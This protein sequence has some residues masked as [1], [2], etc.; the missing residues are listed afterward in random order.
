MEPA[1]ITGGLFLGLEREAAVR[2]SFL[3]AIPAVTASGLFSL[4]DAFEPVVLRALEDSD[5]DERDTA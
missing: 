5:A 4:P 3:L 2:F 1:V